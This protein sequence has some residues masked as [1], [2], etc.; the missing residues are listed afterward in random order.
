MLVR[1]G[2]GHGIARWL[3]GHG[4][5]GLV[6]EYRLPDGNAMRPLED[7]QSAIRA[8][9]ENAEGWGID[10]TRVG[11]LGFS[12]GG[13]V[14]STA[15]THWDA[16][17]A[18][19]RAIGRSHHATSARPDFAILVYPL[20]SL[21]P[22][23]SNERSLRCLLGDD[24]GNQAAVEFFS[25]DLHVNA[26]TPPAFITH[27]EDD[28]ILPIRQSELYYEALKAHGVPARLQRLATGGH[29]Y[30]G[31]KGPSWDAWQASSLDWLGEIGVLPKS[32]QPV[33]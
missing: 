15:S 3:N 2:E 16:E 29:G 27:A 24:Y 17:Y 9:R 26:K 20:I 13:H 19:F 6:L 12:A 32:P 21:F 28:A 33:I 31:Y 1:D 22:E 23:I 25:N 11:I 8:A 18:N 5:T 10:P 14:A 30:N 4:I 7:A